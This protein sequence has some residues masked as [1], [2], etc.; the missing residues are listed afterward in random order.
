VFAA[1]S[2]V[3]EDDT[4]DGVVGGVAE[5]AQAIAQSA[6]AEQRQR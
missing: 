2:V 3:R 1:A 5:S 6:A 4:V